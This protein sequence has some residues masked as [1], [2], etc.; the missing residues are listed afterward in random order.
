MAGAQGNITFSRA[1]LQEIYKFSHG[2]PRLINLL[3]D[4]TLLAGFVEQTYH[5][6]KGIVKKAERSLAGREANSTFA[7]LWAFLSRSIPLPMA[8]LIIF[9]SL[10]ASILSSP[11]TKDFLW[12]KV[13]SVYW[14]ISGDPGTTSLENRGKRSRERFLK[15]FPKEDQR[16]EPDHGGD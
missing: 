15:G 1:A 5:I 2:I 6:H 13:Q 11:K 4:R 3:G 10:S 14:Q 16:R 7:R 9:F 12:A 8:L